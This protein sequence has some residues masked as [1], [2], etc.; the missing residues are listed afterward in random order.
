MHLN[1]KSSVYCFI[2]FNITAI[3]SDDI[4]KTTSESLA[5]FDNVVPVHDH[6][7]PVDCFSEGH[8]ARP[9]LNMRPKGIIQWVGVWRKW[10]HKFF[11]EKGKVCSCRE[12]CS[13]LDV[14]A[15]APSCWNTTVADDM[16]KILLIQ[17]TKLSAS[18]ASYSLA[19]IRYPDGLQIR[20]ITAP[21]D[22]RKPSDMT[23]AGCYVFDK[24][25][26]LS[27]SSPRDT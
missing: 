3:R 1:I 5:T 8:I 16:S 21:L 26:A 12:C 6:P 19:V 27:S 22:A 18:L 2:L 14:C 15:G 11:D 10:G 7:F 9:G 17:A 24:V 20:D 4:P 23:D 25:R 13:R